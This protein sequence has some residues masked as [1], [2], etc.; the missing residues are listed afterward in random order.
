MSTNVIRLSST[1]IVDAVNAM[2]ECADSIREAQQAKE[3]LQHGCGLGE[4]LLVL[5]P[6]NVRMS[7]RRSGAVMPY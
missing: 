6:A 1:S 7:W 2:Q 5:V 3:V 4:S